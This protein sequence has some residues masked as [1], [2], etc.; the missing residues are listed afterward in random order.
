MANKD[1]WNGAPILRMSGLVH[2][3]PTV[4][5]PE[6]KIVVIDQSKNSWYWDPDLD[7]WWM[8]DAE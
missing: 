5:G 8:F 4:S 2:F 7:K 3:H 6:V 1:D